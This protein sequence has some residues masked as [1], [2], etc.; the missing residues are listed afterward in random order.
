MKARK[1]MAVPLL[2]GAFALAACGGG[3][4][5]NGGGSTG[6]QTV[7]QQQASAVEDINAQPR[8]N[9]A[10][11]G[12]LRLAITDFGTNWNPGQVD[13]NLAEL[14]SV[15][16][17]LLPIN[18][19]FDSGGNFTPDPNYLLSAT[20]TTSGPTVVT[21][22]LN[23]KAVWGDGDPIDVDDYIATW[24]ANNGSNTKF[25]TA[26][27]DGFSSVASIKAGADKY[28]VII[29]YK[30]VFPDWSQPWTSVQKAESVKDPNTFNTGWTNLRNDWLSGP[31]KMS[32]FDKTQKVLTLV[33][34]DKW[35]GDKPKL[36]KVTWRAVD[37]DAQ[38]AA[39]QNNELDTFDVGINP[40]AYTRAKAVSGGTVRKANGPDFRQFTFN[41]KAGN[42]ADKAVRQ[43]VVQSLNRSQI[44]ASDLAGITDWKVVPLNNHFLLPG[45]DGYTDNATAT[46]MNYNVVAAKKTLDDDGWVAG[47]DGI[48]AKNGK[49][50]V[51]NISQLTGIAASENEAALA[52]KMLTAVGMKVNL[53]DVPVAKFGTTLSTHAFEIISFSWIGTPYPFANMNQIY[54]TG[55]ESNYAQLSMPDADKLFATIKTTVDKT[56]RIQLANQADKIIWTDVHTL[57][58]YQRPQFIATK[59]TLANFGAFGLAS[60]KWQ[61]IGY[62][63]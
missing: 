36:S 16:N 44:A 29:T 50:L 24:K 21:L 55:S 14:T 11:G 59:S 19:D 37:E 43:A 56:Q 40:D 8:D 22:K 45:Q 51:I 23:P 58:L 30:T 60:P 4:S 32:A 42:I 1:L 38:A 17:S 26:S 47:A 3:N 6:N 41:S 31:F 13:G 62:T 9:V 27:T 63:K 57:P 28:E 10:D 5:G 39:F 48:R 25:Q 20:A 2:A 7:S 52:Q 18:F 54:G 53:V 15:R 33:P 46:N 49:Q 61:D 12:E 34:N 35:W